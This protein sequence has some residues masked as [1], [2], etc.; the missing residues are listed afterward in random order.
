MNSKWE[1]VGSRKVTLQSYI[2]NLK[3]E[4][5]FISC[6]I[7]EPNIFVFEQP[8]PPVNLKSTHVASNS[9]KLCPKIPC[10]SGQR[11]LEEEGGASLRW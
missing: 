8:N 1:G 11:V 3:F 4:V 7:S 10:K 6:I 5:V 2:L 9:D